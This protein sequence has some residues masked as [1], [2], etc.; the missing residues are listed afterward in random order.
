M[1]WRIVEI[2]KRAKLD[3]KLNYLVIRSDET[4]KIH[5]SEIY[6]LLVES[7]AVSLTAALLCE[8]N[9][10][11]I[12]VIFCDEKR[13]P[14]TQLMPYYGSHD[15]S[16]KVR[17]Q[18]AWPADLKSAVWTEIVTEKIRQQAILLEE[19]QK[20]ESEMLRGYI[21]Q[22]EFNDA[23]NREGHAAKVYFNSLFGKTFTRNDD[24]PVNKA[25]NYGYGLLLSTF[26]RE[27]A[28][29]GYL[30]QL[31][32]FHDNQFNFY[33]LSSDL[34][35]PFR[36]LVDRRVARLQPTEFGHNEKVWLLDLLN[37][38]ILIQNKMQTT[39][40]AVRIYCKSV[41]DALESGDLTL[42]RFYRNEL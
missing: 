2:T 22:I 7:T 15:T 26:N 34:M 3:C 29:M 36:P 27:I 14:D 38:E 42:I 21:E 28:A 9:K 41:F 33:N 25:L 23:T 11:K 6:M 5:L 20:P 4:V 35:E 16:A 24:C 39:T 32:L 18:I 37:T 1:S 17:S 13:S 19:L 12:K 30:T 31:G 8:L 40:A 10:R